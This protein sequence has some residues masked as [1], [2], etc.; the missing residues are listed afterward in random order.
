MVIPAPIIATVTLPSPMFRGDD[1]AIPIAVTQGGSPYD[2]TSCSVFM[3]IKKNIND[4]DT[5]AVVKL[6]S[7]ST[8]ITVDSGTGGTC[9]APLTPAMTQGLTVSSTLTLAYEVKIHDSTSLHHTVAQ[10]SLTL[11]QNLDQTD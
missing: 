1:I 4:P 9:T 2:L 6:S 5:G 7:P 10:G 3:M 11:S 8:G